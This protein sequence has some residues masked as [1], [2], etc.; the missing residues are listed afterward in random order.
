MDEM[1][2]R[3]EN[4]ADAS[5]YLD[6][7]INR[8]R[9]A[10]YAYTRLDLQPIG[11]L[12]EGLNRPQDGL[13][14]IHV[15]G[16]KGKGSTCLF[17]E[18]LLQSLGERVG[19]FTSPHLESWLERF[20]VGARPVAEATLISA[21]R[22]VQPVLEPL[23]QGPRETLPSFFDATT[24]I[25]LLIFRAENVDRVLLEVGLGGRLDS[26]NI[27]EPAV[28][29]VTSI[30]LEHTDKLGD[31]EALIAGEKAGI[32]KAGVPAVIG[33]LRAEA[34]EVVRA[35]AERVGAP[36]RVVPAEIPSQ[37]GAFIG[38]V[39]DVPFEVDMATPGVAARGNARLAIECVRALGRYSEGQIAQAVQAVLPHVRLP[40]RCEQLAADPRVLVDT[41][42]T[43]E[44]ARALSVVLQ[45]RA[46]SGYELLLS[47]S[48]DKD[49][50]RVLR[51]LLACAS[52]ITVT[53]ADP[54]R[55]LAADELADRVHALIESMP[56]V[57]DFEAKPEI[58]VVSDPEE[59]CRIARASL[60]EE[61]MLCA[62]GSVYL[63]GIARRVLGA[64]R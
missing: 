29:C 31:T 5:A 58:S 11:A 8:E 45:T 6:G 43:A 28:T 32:L 13:S 16:S 25:A 51:P 22:Q 7:L 55:S 20:R 35:R 64:G 27:V 50:D 24:A 54:T 60:A 1:A 34:M 59:A 41:A 39:G 26:T 10:D 9:Q 47:V 48:G 38:R 44:S 14:I 37:G 42:H 15:A 2:G 53:R 46:A 56:R 36:L 19:T 62:T 61:H 12:L 17:A 30:E 52:R 23:R 33:P 57:A 3:I 4:L 21:V 18:A 49:V 40:G 63:A